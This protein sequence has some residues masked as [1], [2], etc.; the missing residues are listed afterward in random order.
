M[1]TLSA[2]LLS[3][4]LLAP[5]PV[6]AEPRNTVAIRD[7]WFYVNGERFFVKGICYFEV[8]GINGEAVQNSLEVIDH[9]FRMIKEA[10]FNTVK[11]L[12]TADRIAAAKK[13]GLMIAQPATLSCFSKDYQSPARIAELK[14]QADEWVGLTKPFDNVLYY[15]MDNEPSVMSVYVQHEKQMEDAWRMLDRRVK[16]LQPG[17]YTSVQMMPPSAFADVSMCDV[18]SLN[19]YPFH[20]GRNSIGYVA[21]ADW[22]RRTFAKNKPFVFSE[23][24]WTDDVNEFGARMTALM[25][26]QIKAGAVG[27]YLFIWRAWAGEKTSDNHW[28][29]IIPNQAKPD[30]YRNEPR[31]ILRDY[32]KYFEAVAIE[33]KV[34]GM[35][36]RRLPLEIY[37]TDR[38]RTVDVTVGD[39]TAHLEKQGQYWWMGELSFGAELHGEQRVTVTAKDESDA[40]LVTKQIPVFLCEQKKSL[41]VKI[42]R[43]AKTLSQGDRYTAR[44]T[45]TDE[46]GKPVPGALLKLGV[47]QSAQDLW[48]SAAHLAAADAKGEYVFT[49]D[50]VAPGYFHLMAGVD[51]ARKDVETFADVDIVRVERSTAASSKDV[52]D[53]MDF[54]FAWEAAA[55]PGASASLAA[56]EDG[57][58]KALELSYDLAGGRWAV[59]RGGTTHDLRDDR[60]IRFKFRDSGIK[61]RIE[62]KIEDADGSTFLTHLEKRSSDGQ[63]ETAE[64]FMD[65]L[66]YG[67][68]GDANLDRSAVRLSFAVA[69]DEPGPGHS[70]KLTVGSIEGFR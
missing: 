52:L 4:L 46:K 44:I 12:L 20:P 32:Q 26:E 68:G 27:A 29:G 5:T 41:S 56:V 16:T 18:T 59:M 8:H 14:R 57:A 58:V 11:S 31:P 40:T 50:H 43:D 24:G 60:G 13:Y 39:R 33:P 34:N 45:V 30:D 63:W 17:A 35:Y 62:V 64:V 42:R 53:G 19:L 51:T 1:R 67:W 55:E 48:S 6:R 3:L 49:Q 21:Y 38:T 28:W 47:N 9:E 65:D 7:G 66:R 61:D 2:A 10:G 54:L 25:D 37:G 36:A 70:G 23:Y 15:V 22:Y 69:C